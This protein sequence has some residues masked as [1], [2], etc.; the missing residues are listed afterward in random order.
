M[1]II[2]R[3][4]RGLHNIVPVTRRIARRPYRTGRYAIK[5]YPSIS[6]TSIRHPAASIPDIV[7]DKL[8]SPS[9]KFPY[10]S[11]TNPEPVRPRNATASCVCRQSYS[12]LSFEPTRRQRPARGNKAGVMM[13]R[14]SS[15]SFSDEQSCHQPAEGSVV[16]VG[17]ME[18]ARKKKNKGRCCN[19]QAS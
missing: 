9:H 13:V 16:R 7:V 2:T 5:L 8:P 3:Y 14:H 17:C 1:H 4:G 10:E 19:R 18:G 12:Q 11:R 6:R 15:P